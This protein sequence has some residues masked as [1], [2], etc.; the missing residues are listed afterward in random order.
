[1]ERKRVFIT[2]KTYPTISE[3]YDE[4]VCTAGILEDGSWVRLY[5]LPFRKLNNDKKYGKYDWIEVDIEK[6]TKDLRPES[7]RVLNIDTIQVF[8][9]QKLTPDQWEA[10]KRIIFNKQKIYTNLSELISESREKDI[11]L[12]IFKPAQ[13]VDFVFQETDREWPKE[14]L[15]LL[16]NKAKQLS[17]FETESEM[18]ENFKV[19]QKLP[20]KFSYIFHDDE[21]RESS[22]MIEDWEIGMLY[23]HCLEQSNGDEREAL[24]KV[25]SK[26]FVELPK[27]D[28]HFFLGTTLA[29]HRIAPNPFIIIGLFCPPVNQQNELF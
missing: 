16:S 23:R 25:K 6:S 8:P 2:V 4:L 17:L 13:I 9:E 10:R 14:K 27:K 20:Y 29:Y 18:I 5:P 28:M 15:E 24:G 19:V 7:Y 12:G 3:K 11:S 21:G 22:L 1:M 26:Y